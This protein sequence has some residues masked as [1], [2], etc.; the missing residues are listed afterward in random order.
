MLPLSVQEIL[1]ATGGISCTLTQRSVPKRALAKNQIISGISTDTRMMKPGEIF[2]ALAGNHFDGHA[3]V[4]EALRKG[5]VGVVVQRSGKNALAAALRSDAA[6]KNGFFIIS[7]KDTLAAYGDIA[8]Y[9]RKK[10]TIPLI[11]I[12]G[13]NGKTTTK[14]MACSVLSAKFGVLKNAGTQNNEIGLSKTLLALAPEHDIG[15]L[16]LG[17]NHRGEIRRLAQILKPGVGIITNIGPS[18]LEFLKSVEG[19]YREKRSLIGALDKGATAIINGDDLFLGRIQGLSCQKITFG[20]AASCD[21]RASAIVR[22]KGAFIFR[23]NDRYD[24]NIKALGIHNIYNALAAIAVGLLFKV[25]YDA[26][27]T[28]LA[29]Y[30]PIGGRLSLRRFGDIEVIDDS[31][32]ANPASVSNALQVLSEYTCAGNRVVVC[33]DMCELGKDAEQYHTNMGRA[34]AVMRA[35]YVIAVGRFAETVREAALQHGMSGEQ[36]FACKDRSEA[37]GLLRKILQPKDVVLVKG[38]RRI[39]LDEVVHALSSFVPATRDMVRV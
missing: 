8:R 6:A 5:A 22:R 11:G 32:N 23:V 14:E 15:V 29:R 31:Y 9:Y 10:F 26:M 35:D 33:G 4:A 17:S 20:M 27:Y 2:I 36:V 39:Q 16:E 12:T 30:Q 7:V 3:F 37:V 21:V 28:A 1:K 25:D 38:S 24:F 19:V 13:S 18:H 34:A